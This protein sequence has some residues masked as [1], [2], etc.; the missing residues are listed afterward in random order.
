MV[1]GKINAFVFFTIKIAHGVIKRKLKNWRMVI[2]FIL[3]EKMSV[4]VKTKNLEK[5]FEKISQ[6]QKD[7]F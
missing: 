1:W 3:K 2:G 6:L 5:H 4:T 7:R